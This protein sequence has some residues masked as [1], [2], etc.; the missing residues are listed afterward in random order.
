M[1]YKEIKT[2]AFLAYK[3][4]LRGN[5]STSTL[6]IFVLSLSFL[7][8][9][10]ISGMLFGLQRLMIDTVIDVFSSQV[11]ISAQQEPRVKSYIPNQDDLRSQIQTIPGVIATSR[12]YLLAGSIGFDKLHNGVYKH[13]SG[14]IVGF[15]PEEEKYVLSLDKFLLDGQWLEKN[16]RDK[17]LFSSALA[18]GYDLFAPSDLGGVRVGDEVRITYSNGTVRQ[19]HVKG[20]YNDAIGLFE[21]FITT[22][23]AESV[24]STNNEATQILVKADLS[25]VPLEKLVEQ[26]EQIAPKLKI[27]PYTVL[28]GSFK[29]FLDALNLIAGIVSAISVLVA[30][31][32]MFSLIYVNAINKR[33][34]IG[35]MKAIGIKKEIVILSYVFQSLFYAVCGVVIGY[36]FVFYVLTPLLVTYPIDVVFGKLSL[37]H[38]D[39]TTFAGMGSL[40]VTSF[41]AGLVP[42][43][44]IAK[45]DILKAIFR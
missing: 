31:I 22:N 18:G 42:S 16:D 43:W 23:E 33:R 21:T 2:A 15:D 12:H 7:N 3:T 20:I 9:L 10:F 32:T 5:R 25:R 40:V 11:M 44:G 14:A 35:I 28:L 34:Q 26:I 45:G 39:V 27:Q 30:A 8:M 29:S 38:D 1:T 19:Y 24:L 6:L 17:I 41:F 36:L 13:I 37:A 4:I